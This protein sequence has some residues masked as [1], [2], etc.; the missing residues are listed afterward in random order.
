MFMTNYELIY[1]ESKGNSNSFIPKNIDQPAPGKEKGKAAENAAKAAK[2]VVGAHIAAAK[3]AGGAVSKLSKKAVDYAKS[4]DA[5]EK[6][7]LAKEKAGAAFAG[8]KGKASAFA[9]QRKK[10]TIVTP[11]LM[12]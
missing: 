4:D 12:M 9:A 3:F 7:A 10:L 2:A 11:T 1:G 5:A 8:L 6:A